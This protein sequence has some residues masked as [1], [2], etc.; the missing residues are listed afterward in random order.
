MD[1]TSKRVAK[2]TGCKTPLEEHHW[3]IPSKFCD[4]FQKSSPR[5]EVYDAS[6][7]KEED[8]MPSLIEELKALEMEEQALWRQ[9]SEERLHTRITE[10]RKVIKEL[11]QSKSQQDNYRADTFSTRE[12]SKLELDGAVGQQTPPDELL[13]TID[14]VQDRQMGGTTWAAQPTFNRLANYSSAMASIAK[15]HGTV[16]ETRKDGKG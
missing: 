3:G 15:Q 8:I 5:K 13:K 14:P 1:N 4:G 16:P 6:L 10:K 2:C 7:D 12:L 11:Q 9:Q